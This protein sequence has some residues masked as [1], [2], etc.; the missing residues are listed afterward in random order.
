MGAGSSPNISSAN[1]CVNFEHKRFWT[2][3]LVLC[4]HLQNQNSLAQMFTK[5]SLRTRV[6]NIWL[7]LACFKHPSEYSRE[8]FSIIDPVLICM[9]MHVSLKDCNPW[10][11]SLMRRRRW[12][13][14][15]N[16]QTW[17]QDWISQETLICTKIILW[18]REQW[19]SFRSF[20]IA[21]E[22]DNLQ[23]SSCC[24]PIPLWLSDYGYQTFMFNDW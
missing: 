10:L 11:C 21:P 20:L 3:R 22:D 14:Y 5:P 2:Q 7:K 12:N 23:S 15:F 17:C 13:C 6:T 19:L 16:H 1:I 24:L 8:I 9:K 4:K 18:S